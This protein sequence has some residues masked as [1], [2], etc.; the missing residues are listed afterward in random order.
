MEEERLV[1]GGG[2]GGPGDVGPP[3]VTGMTVVKV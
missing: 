3:R 2:K 1:T